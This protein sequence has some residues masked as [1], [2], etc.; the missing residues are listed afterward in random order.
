ML[1][2]EHAVRQRVGGVVREDRDG[3]L[4]DDGTPVEL[5]VHEVD[6][7]PRLGGSASEH[8]FM[9][10]TPVHPRS[11]ERGEQSRVDIN[12]PLAK[13]RDHACGEELQV[14]GEDEEVGVGQRSE[15][16]VGVRRVAQHRG[17]DAGAPGPVQCA[18]VGAIGHDVRDAGRGLGPEG[19]E[20]SLQIR[21][22]ARNEDGDSQRGPPGQLGRQGVSDFG[23]A[24]FVTL[25]T[26]APVAYLRPCVFTSISYGALSVNVTTSRALHLPPESSSEL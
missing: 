21:A 25:R 26:K 3:S 7:G 6:C 1:H 10:A 14:T 16:L 24:P 17:P 22:A 9:H 12:R 4:R 13:A 8:R 18:S 23:L 5:L 20:Q 2:G 19:V 15:E 11:A